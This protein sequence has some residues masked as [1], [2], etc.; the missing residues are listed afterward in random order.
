[1]LR[2]ALE[3]AATIVIVTDFSLAGI[4]DTA[5]LFGFAT[6]FAPNAKR[7]VV[8][9]R[10]GAAKKGS[11]SAVEVEKAI[12]VKFA[13]IIPEDPIFIPHA[14]NAG[15]PLP[16]SAPTSP[17]IPALLALAEAAG[18]LTVTRKPGLIDRILSFVKSAG[19]KS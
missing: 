11:V 9:N 2:Q 16:E 4:R 1:V 6:K 3:Q 13:A 10:L 14:V 12:G 7:L 17:A 18:C 5:R 19:D 15:K 8:G